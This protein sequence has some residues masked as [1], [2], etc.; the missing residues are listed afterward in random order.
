[1][2]SRASQ[3][4]IWI[5]EKYDWALNPDLRCINH[6]SRHPD[7]SGARETALELLESS[8]SAEGFYPQNSGH[9]GG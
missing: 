8:D 2:H 3:T 7:E 6:A 5:E 4:V 1:V 9:L